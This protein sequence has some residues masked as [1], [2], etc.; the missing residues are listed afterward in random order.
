MKLHFIPVGK[1]APPLPRSPETF[2]SFRIQSGPFSMISLVLYQ[3]PR[4]S[5][6]LSLVGRVRERERD[7][8]VFLQSFRSLE[9]GQ[10]GLALYV[11]TSS[12]PGHI[13]WW[14][15]G[16]GHSEGHICFFLALPGHRE[17]D[18]RKVW[19]IKWP[20][21]IMHK[22]F[23]LPSLDD[24]FHLFFIWWLSLIHQIIILSTPVII[25]H[26]PKWWP[27]TKKSI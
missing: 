22:K 26:S 3:S 12:H 11:F 17:E 7:E 6:P 14:I 25:S 4:L 2:T 23:E 21:A 13:S 15:S 10:N 27:M 9:T 16:L 20:C 5:D 24:Y 18:E 8:Q 1:P 19:L